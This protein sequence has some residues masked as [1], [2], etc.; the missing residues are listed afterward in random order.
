[1]EGGERAK[2]NYT[3]KDRMG[4]H[5]KYYKVGFEPANVT[6]TLT[7]QNPYANV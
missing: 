7:I 4:G 3:L 2:S 6:T 5:K 1:M